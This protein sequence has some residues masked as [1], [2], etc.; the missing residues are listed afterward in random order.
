MKNLNLARSLVFFDL[1]T[2]SSNVQDAR[3]VQ[4]AFIKIF[5]QPEESHQTLTGLLNPG[6]PIPAEATA[7][8]GITD[9]MVK[10]AP[11]FQQQSEAISKF[12]DQCDFAGFNILNYDL[13]VLKNEFQR[14]GMLFDYSRSK[15]IDSMSIYHH[16]FPRDLT[17]ACQQYCGKKLEGAHGA[18][19]DTQATLEVFLKQLETHF[20]PNCTLA[21]IEAVT[22]DQDK[23]VDRERKFSWN[24]QGEACFTF[25]KH[26]NQTLRTVRNL[27][28]NYLEWI[29]G[30]SFSSE[31]KQ[32]CKSALYDSQFPKKG[33]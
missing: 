8:H 12:I 9:E 23:F 16:F 11:T 5:P 24:A 33:E 6:I 2:T 21:D 15:V 3:I 25:G 27:A 31:V 20:Q 13:P 29:I 26:Q 22:F 10:D 32:I 1:E 7:I 14:A 30:G 4:Y 18:M 19:V 28:P 17:A